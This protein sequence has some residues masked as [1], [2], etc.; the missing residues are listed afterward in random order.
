MKRILALMVLLSTMIFAHAPLLSVDDNEDGTVYLEGGFSNGSSAGG[1]EIL[2]LE[3]KDYN[4]TEESFE[5]KKVLYKFNL[6]EEGMADEVLKPKVV[7]YLIAMNAGPGHIVIKEG[8]RLTS[9]ELE[10]WAT[11]LEDLKED[12][13]A[14][15]YIEKL[16]GN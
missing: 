1:V 7:S 11:Y 10:D 16:Q 5:G 6:D 12:G 3:D 15:V 4:G 14:E 13:K 9:D 2:F 8:P